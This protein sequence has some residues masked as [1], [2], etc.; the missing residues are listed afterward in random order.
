M[1]LG[2]FDVCSMRSRGVPTDTCAANEGSGAYEK[3]PGPF[4]CT[5][6]ATGGISTESFVTDEIKE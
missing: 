6:R 2:P 4:P 5:H 3:V 1:I